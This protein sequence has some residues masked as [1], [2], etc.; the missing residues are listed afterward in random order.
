MARRRVAKK[1]EVLGDPVYGDTL[2]TKFINSLMYDGKK[3]LSL[4]EY[5]TR[6]SN[7]LRSV[8]VRKV[9]KSS[10]RLLRM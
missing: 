2:V 10:V 3:N 4:R 9:L 6:R 7:L 8:P 1:R 5:S